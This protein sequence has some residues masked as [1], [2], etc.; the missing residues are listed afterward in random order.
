MASTKDKIEMKQHLERDRP[1]ML[2]TIDPDGEHWVPLLQDIQGNILKAHG[3]DHATH[4]FLRFK[5]DDSQCI[6]QIKKQI[7]AWAPSITSAWKALQEASLYRN[8]QVPG[9]LFVSFFLTK[10]GYKA[11]GEEKSS[12]DDT[13]F[14]KGMKGSFIQDKNGEDERNHLNDP[15][16]YTWDSGYQEEIHAM[17]L[18]A[19]DNKELLA[20]SEIKVLTQVIRGK[21]NGVE[22]NL[23][24]V[25]QVE[26]GSVLRNQDE[27]PIEHF[28]YADGLSNPLFLTTDEP[29]GGEDQWNP[30]APLGLVLV[31]DKG[32]KKGPY[33][34]GSYLVFRKLEQNVHQF[35]MQRWNLAQALQK[36][37][38]E[39][40][41]RAG[42]K[43]KEPSE[44]EK[45]GLEKK[46]LQDTGALMV[47]RHEDGTSLMR[48]T[49]DAVSRSYP[50]GYTPFNNFNYKE[51]GAGST[52]PFHAHVRRAN[53]RLAQ[54][55]K[56]RI[57]RRGIPY[58]QRTENL[59]EPDDAL[60]SVGVGLLFMCYQSDV[61]DQF[62]YLQIIANGTSKKDP[63]GKKVVDAIIGQVPED[64]RSVSF[65]DLVTLKGGEYFFAPSISYLTSLGE[66]K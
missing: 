41:E 51:D 11:L 46:A 28:G 20:A 56:H 6:P 21:S 40:S 29:Y 13:A 2:P 43:P 45:E 25:V 50:Q 16:R 53:P 62:E 4:I 33:S 14:Q 35:K 37:E 8:H 34:C 57:V 60:P 65:V 61:H 58:G 39:K 19:D 66:S 49:D 18:L 24:D 12:P 44:A 23:A 64:Q 59:N 30:W 7:A 54:E 47:G 3:R 22:C 26:R 31:Q 32:G 17:I 63:E 1:T 52:C 55:L 15:A 48:V 9:S 36:E 38:R 5:T 27:R 10:A 42:K